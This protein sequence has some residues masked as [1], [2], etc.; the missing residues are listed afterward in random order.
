MIFSFFLKSVKILIEHRIYAFWESR[1]V[2][3]NKFCMRAI[4]NLFFFNF[5]FFQNM[6]KFLWNTEF[7][8]FW[9]IRCGKF[10][11]ARD[12]NDFFFEIL[13]FSEKC[14]YP[15]KR[16]L[17]IFRLSGMRNFYRCASKNNFFEIYFFLKSVKIPIEENYVFLGI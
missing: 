16:E 4:N 13:L 1:D 11:Q 5:S 14:Q 17:C 2:R 8:Y 10:L 9:A 12:K 7:I 6:S 3:C 15:D